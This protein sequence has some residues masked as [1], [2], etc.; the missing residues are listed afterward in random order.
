MGKERKKML[1]GEKKNGTRIDKRCDTCFD[2]IYGFVLLNLLQFENH[3]FMN[4]SGVF[5]SYYTA[6]IRLWCDAFEFRLFGVVCEPIG[7]ADCLS[8]AIKFEY[9]A[10]ACTAQQMYV[11]RDASD[12]LAEGS[13]AGV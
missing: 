10:I 12:C 9:D 6:E 8:A 2:S 5:F 11:L 4:V 7:F 1:D 13:L 3:V